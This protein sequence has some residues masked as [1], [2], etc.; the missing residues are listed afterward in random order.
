M[1]LL[2][3]IK[4]FRPV[5]GSTVGDGG[6]GAT[7]FIDT[8]GWQGV[9][10]LFTGTSG[11]ASSGTVIIQQ[12]SA[13]S[14]GLGI[15]QSTFSNK[16]HSSTSTRKVGAID[17]YRPIKRYVRLSLLT[18]TGIQVTAIAYSGRRL[19][20]TEAGVYSRTTRF[21]PSAVHVCTT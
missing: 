21:V 7:T 2:D 19:G 5:G 13:A 16:I 10:F 20:S 1:N 11:V 3:S 15:M 17:V 8:Q 14:T 4:L 12:S 6:P 18:C 9:L